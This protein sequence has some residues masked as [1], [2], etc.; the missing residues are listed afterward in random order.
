V[1]D[2]AC[3]RF[4]IACI[5]ADPGG[6]YSIDAL[7]GIATIVLAIIGLSGVKPEVLV[8]ISTIVFG[9][10]LLIQAGTIL[11]EFAEIET[12]QVT[13][14]GTGG[15]GLSAL[16]LV[17]IAGIVLGVLKLYALLLVIASLFVMNALGMVI[18]TV[19]A[20]VGQLVFTTNSQVMNR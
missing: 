7:G 4:G 16:F 15:G 6:S 5:A 20:D 13:D 3:R 12:A 11:N 2:V 19:V 8:S 17:G 18:V 10:A 9:A 14:V 1:G